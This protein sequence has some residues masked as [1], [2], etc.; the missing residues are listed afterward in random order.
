MSL[1]AKL[2]S[3]KNYVCVV[4]QKGS[5]GVVIDLSNPN[6]QKKLNRGNYHIESCEFPIAFYEKDNQTFLIH[7]TD[8]NRLDITCLETDELL[9]DRIVDYDTDSNYFD[10]FHSALL[11]SPD[12]KNFTSNGWHWHPFGQIYCFKIDDFLE[13]FEFAK[14]EVN[15]CDEYYYDLDWDRP[16]CWVDDRTLAVGF[17]KQVCDENQLKYQSE[18]LFYDTIKQKIVNRTEFDGFGITFEGNV[19]G[20]LFYDEENNQFLGLNK[21]SGLLISNV[22]GKQI[23]RDSTFTNYKYSPHHKLFYQ[24]EKEYLNFVPKNQITC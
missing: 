2:Y 21:K 4:Q 18:I 19:F 1:N 16:L 14:M 5:E 23:F 6:F 22:E 11:V 3:F 12:G 17:N 9:T 24:F 7:G 8:W 20:E 10:Y 15:V 13:K